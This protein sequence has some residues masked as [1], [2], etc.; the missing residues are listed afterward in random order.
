MKI[1]ISGTPGSGKT[2]VGKILSKKLNLKFYDIGNLRKK[3]AK[4]KNLTL[5]QYNKLGEKSSKTDKK[6]DSKIKQIGEK[7]N[8]LIV[9]RLAPYFIQDSIKIFLKA[10][11]QEGSKRILKDKKRLDKNKTLKQTKKEIIARLKS[12][13]KRYKKYYNI[14]IDKLKY[15]LKITTTNLTINQV[16]NKILKLIRK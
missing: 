9:G 6:F 15:D 4:E 2:I 7:N 16:I 12:D 1:T 8:F 13:K 3:E 11:V 14:D 5:N 10:S